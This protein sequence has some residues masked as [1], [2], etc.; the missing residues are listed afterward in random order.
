MEAGKNNS[1]FPTVDSTIKVIAP[2]GTDPLS[3]KL[4]RGP[5]SL[6]PLTVVF[7]RIVIDWPP[8]GDYQPIAAL[9]AYQCLPP[10]DPGSTPVILDNFDRV[11]WWILGLLW[12]QPGPR[13]PKPSDFEFQVRTSLAGGISST[14][15]IGKTAFNEWDDGGFLVG[16]S[17]ILCSQWEL[18]ARLPDGEGH[19]AGDKLKLRIAGAADRMA[20]GA[21]AAFFGNIVGDHAPL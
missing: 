1:P 21:Y 10:G 17:G 2:V 16:V 12:D 19:V 14:A 3:G 15:A 18:W 4:A 5:D 20:G 8:N 11:T 9:A 13:P 6:R 7:P